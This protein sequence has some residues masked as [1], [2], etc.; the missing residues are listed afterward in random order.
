MKMVV[1]K[2]AYKLPVENVKVCRRKSLRKGRF[3]VK[4]ARIFD[5]WMLQHWAGHKLIV[6]QLLLHRD[7][8]IFPYS[9]PVSDIRFLQ[10]LKCYAVF[11]D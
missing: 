7:Y 1:S 3:A 11:T 2:P 8:H 10:P 9:V 4:W 6:H 5:G